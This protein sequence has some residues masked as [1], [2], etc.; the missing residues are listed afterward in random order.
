[1]HPFDQ[2]TS[3]EGHASLVDE[4]YDD[5]KGVKVRGGND[6]KPMLSFHSA[7]QGRRSTAR[8]RLTCLSPLAFAHSRLG[9]RGRPP[10]G[11]L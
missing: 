6:R 10:G 3:W 4:L 8:V 1:M 7:G 5:L 2:A 9:G 11:R